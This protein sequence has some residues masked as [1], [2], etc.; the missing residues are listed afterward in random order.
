MR[1]DFEQIVSDIME[2]LKNSGKS[3]YSEFY[4][5]ITNDARRR[6]F[7]EHHV[8]QNSWWIY[9]T[10]TSVE[11]ARRVERYFLDMGMRGGDGGGNE[12]STVVYCYAV[13]P[14]TVE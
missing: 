11:E 7:E 4:I 10:A 5:G 2:H 13:T 9:R 1:K 6:L 8:L 12:T 14:K 3:Y